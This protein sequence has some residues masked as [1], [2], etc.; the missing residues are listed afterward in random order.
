M[1][2]IRK[3]IFSVCG[4]F[5]VVFVFILN[6]IQDFWKNKKKH[7]IPLLSESGC[8]LLIYTRG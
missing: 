8:N 3:N 2:L 6:N 1:Q 4:V 7:P 5:L